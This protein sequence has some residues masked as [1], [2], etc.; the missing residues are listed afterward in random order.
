MKDH[1]HISGKYKYSAHRDF[2]INVELNHKISVIFHNLKSYDSHLIMQGQGKFNLKI[3]VI[4]NGIE[5]YMSF[6][7]N[8]KLRFI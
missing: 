4:T 3:N 2:N 7:I 1:C 5:K 6:S 8:N